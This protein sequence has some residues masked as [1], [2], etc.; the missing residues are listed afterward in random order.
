[1][2]NTITA[3]LGDMIGHEKILILAFSSYAIG[4]LFFVLGNNFW[5]FLPFALFQ[6]IGASQESGAL[7]AWFDN[8][9]RRLSNDP[10]TK[11]YGSFKGKLFFVFRI[12]SGA[13]FMISG[14]IAVLLSRRFLFVLRFIGVILIIFLIIALIKPDEV[15]KQEAEKNRKLSHYLSG[16]LCYILLEK[17]SIAFYFFG[18]A[19]ITAAFSSI[20]S[21]FLLFPLYY[22][23]SGSDDLVGLLR[24]LILVAG[25][26]WTLIGIRISKRVDH[27]PRN[28]FILKILAF[29]SF[30]LVALCF[31]LTVPPTN[32]LVI[33]SFLGLIFIFQFSSLGF[34]LD[35]ILRERLML[36]IIPDEFRNSL[37][38]LIPTL[39]A[40]LSLPL[41]VIGGIVVTNLG[42]I[43]AVLLILIIN[44]IGIGLIGFS[45]K[46]GQEKVFTTRRA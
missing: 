41:I 46:F 39:I 40:L 24:S 11:I 21:N 10:E 30:L 9:Y 32:S 4:L 16:G 5:E 13:C 14:I 35:Y 17:R 3:A 27:S 8:Q 38:S 26:F 37:Y 20:W 12:T 6:G 23:Y 36:Q 31:Y 7:E 18:L 25:A 29:P 15:R 43:A 22:S 1:L 19:L 2:T 44:S 33:Q 42:F 45:F 28:I 34:A